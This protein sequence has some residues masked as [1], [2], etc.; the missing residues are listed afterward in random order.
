MQPQM[1]RSFLPCALTL[2]LLVSASQ[3]APVWAQSARD[4]EEKSQSKSSSNS[5]SNSNRSSSS[6]SS[7]NSNQSARDR[8]EKA[9]GRSSRRNDDNDNRPI[10]VY[11]DPYYY[12]PYGYG[13]GGAGSITYLRPGGMSPRIAFISDMGGCPDLYIMRENGTYLQ[14]LTRTTSIETQPVFSPQKGRLGFILDADQIVLMNADGAKRMTI[15]VSA[16]APVRDL[17]WQADDK[18]VAF[19]SEREGNA[20]I[21]TVEANGRNLRRLTNH[22]AA[23]TQPI[24]SPGGGR[25]VFVS[26]RDGSPALYAMSTDG[27][28]EIR[29][30]SPVDLPPIA[31][32][33]YS[34]DG[35]TVAFVAGEGANRDLYTLDMSTGKA[36]LRVMDL[37]TIRRP[38]FSPDGKQIAFSSNR[39]GYFA[40]FVLKTNY[41]D[42]ARQITFGPGNDTEPAW[43]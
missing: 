42:P 2:L 9:Q 33:A 14:R 37:G 1:K 22:P 34:P 4:R 29:R 36:T 18:R 7:S 27:T 26:T 38:V 31:D 39:P 10:Y 40:L 35:N 15:N 11:N 23:D 8:E 16:L 25:M 43:W 28:G 20:E 24:F 12:S 3:T 41:K 17:V 32:P 19:V 5:N 6:S 21:Y 13:A 30:I